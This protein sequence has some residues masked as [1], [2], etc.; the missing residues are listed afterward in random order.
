MITL[1]MEKLASAEYIKNN[2][3]NC[4]IYDILH[5]KSNKFLSCIVITL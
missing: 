5:V 4:F 2:D 3:D 1:L